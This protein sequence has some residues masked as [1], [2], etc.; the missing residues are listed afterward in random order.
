MVD[1][2]ELQILDGQYP[3]E[4]SQTTIELLTMFTQAHTKSICTHF[5]ID[6]YIDYISNPTTQVKN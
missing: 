1:V 3:H 5:Y 2:N 6:F 4:T